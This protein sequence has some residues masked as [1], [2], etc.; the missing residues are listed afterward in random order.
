MKHNVDIFR[1]NELVVSS[2]FCPTIY[3]TS[4]DNQFSHPLV[5]F[6]NIEVEKLSEINSIYENGCTVYD[7]YTHLHINL[8]FAGDSPGTQLNLPFVMFSGN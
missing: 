8:V 2:N 4:S 3:P 5:S 1:R 7:K 6:F